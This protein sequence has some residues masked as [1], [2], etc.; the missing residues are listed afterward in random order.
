MIDGRTCN[1]VFSTFLFNLTRVRSCKAA[2]S[3]ARALL[4]IWTVCVLVATGCEEQTMEDVKAEV[5]LRSADGRSITEL[6]RAPTADEL[7]QLRPSEHDIATVSERLRELGFVV[8][9]AGA[10]GVSISAN[11]ETFERVFKVTLAPLTGSGGERRGWVSDAPLSIPEVLK[12]YV[13]E[14]AVSKAP[15]FFQ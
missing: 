11:K 15:E 5:I 9:A 2:G 7:E 6:D 13:A 8:E 12:P 3:I 10:V 1:T 14:V 4:M